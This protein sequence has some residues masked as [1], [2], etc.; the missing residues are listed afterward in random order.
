M[1]TLSDI[2]HAWQC[3]DPALISYLITLSQQQE[4][5]P[6]ISSETLTFER[7]LTKIY[8]YS[9][10]EL[11]A[12][13]QF[14][15]RTEQMRLL[16]SGQTDY[17]LPERLKI[18]VLLNA[19]WQDGSA[20]ARHVLINAIQQ[21]PIVFG[22]WRAFK[23]IYKQ[24]EQRC[25]YQIAAEIAIRVDKER[26]QA[27]ANSPSLAT[28]TY[29]S[30]RAW[31]F[32]RKLGESLPISYP[33]AAIYYLAAYP[34][35]TD[36]SQTWIA[37]HIWHHHARHAYGRH[38]FHA[39]RQI[40][41]KDRAFAHTWQ[42]QAEPLFRLL[43]LARAEKVRAYACL[44]LKTDFKAQLRQ[45]SVK[46]LLE[47]AAIPIQS[48]A[49]DELLIWLFNNSPQFEQQQLKTIGLH[50]V[51][52]QLLES[53]SNEA[54]NYACAYAQTYARDL[55]LADLL[56]LAENNHQAVRQFA[57]QQIS[58]R[59]PRDEVG[60]N[61]WGLLLDSRFHSQLAGKNLQQHFSQ[62]ELSAEWFAERL[63]TGQQY[64]IDFCKQYLL[65]LHP[66]KTLG[67]AY[68][69]QILL[70]F[71]TDYSL[72][73]R[74]EFIFN[75]I[76][77]LGAEQLNTEVLQRQL[78][79]PLCQNLLLHFLA[80][81]TI[82][83]S[84]LSMSYC[85]ALAYEPDWLTNEWLSQQRAN[86][87]W[88]RQLN[89]NENLAETMRG[90][91]ADVR[92]FAP[93]SLGFDWLMTLANRDEPRYH[94]FAVERIIKAFVPA[95]FAP[96]EPVSSQ[97]NNNSSQ[98]I[99]LQQQSFLFTGKLST[100]TREQ[101]EQKVD[102]ANGK[103]A[104]GINA[105]LDYLVI[106]DEGSPL[107]GN[108]RK[109]SKQVKAESL[110]ASG[111][112]IK[113][114]SETAFLQMLAGTR[115]EASTDRVLAGCEV[116][117]QM[118]LAKP[119][120]ANSRLALRYLRYHH[121]QLCLQLS[122]R[123]VDPDAELPNDFLTFARFQPLF[124]HPLQNI[125]QFALDIAQWELRRWSPTSAELVNLCESRHADVQNF[126][127]QALLA[128]ENLDNQHY[129]LEAATLNQEAVYGLCESKN[130]Q[131]RQLGMAIIEK[132]QIFQQPDALFQLTE[133]PD[134]AIRYAIMRLLWRLYKHY[135]TTVQWQPKALAVPQL[136]KVQQDKIIAYNA[137]RGTGLTPR[138]SQWPATPASLQALLQRWLYE[139]PPA[140]LAKEAIHNGQRLL[141]ANVAKRALI[142]T[143]RDLALEDAE[144]AQLVLPVL[145]NF[146]YSRGKM[147]QSACLVAV[148]RIRHVYP[149]FAG[150]S[151]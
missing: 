118:A 2:Q 24:A 40:Q 73:S 53:P 101:A 50:G 8:S 131:T 28:K 143:M 7:W 111:A 32:L 36:W 41:L 107:Y 17:I 63:L 1:I 120:S 127:H 3:K 55:P 59:H 66:L 80:C 151:L 60:L 86:T 21:L 109:G 70:A 88:L 117:W 6:P 113:I 146:S 122:D 75:C 145:S 48:V 58:S 78:L 9:F 133:S 45:V 105:K 29:I 106:G 119:D 43:S 93:A 85:Q 83:P 149:Q 15:Y 4:P 128:E 104:S 13:S 68:F 64:S 11:P 54:Q 150:M 35:N 130:Q 123:P 38:H 92:R 116:L 47:L 141:S 134:R 52:L 90:W 84:Q 114:I 57:I 95:D 49:R 125:R 77:Q 148:T 136:G 16:E 46:Q 44:A 79:H 94:D 103:N 71:G 26:Y 124:H 10:R 102:D 99:N 23:T 126:V 139:L 110:I 14:S 69:E 31:R 121:P 72:R 144:F 140:R 87:E 27:H 82:K 39:P 96:T 142:E 108:G 22:V 98:S 19:L 135:A 33:E 65:A 56:R 91:L 115:T 76:K 5:H 61:A 62:Q 129:R 138:P 30:L 112:N 12:D 132:N 100:M 74:I 97:V 137:A 20:Y 34:E 67:M 42:R 81:D 147:E 51:V 89:F 37:N 25:D 18:Y